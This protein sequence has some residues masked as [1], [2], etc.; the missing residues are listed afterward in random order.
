MQCQSDEHFDQPRK[1]YGRPRCH[2]DHFL[3][4]SRPRMILEESQ[5]MNHFRWW[6][7]SSNGLALTTASAIDNAS[8]KI[9]GEHLEAVQGLP[10]S[11][12]AT[13][14]FAP[15]GYPMDNIHSMDSILRMAYWEI[16]RRMSKETAAFDS[17]LITSFHP[18]CHG[19]VFADI[20]FNKW[21]SPFFHIFR[22]F[23]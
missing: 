16:L 18:L 23:P 15:N 7:W 10:F 20:A 9:Y 3:M 5:L 1:P 4:V 22:W 6:E 13:S 19:M 17:F 21:H 14:I 12:S 11:A 8:I 2:H